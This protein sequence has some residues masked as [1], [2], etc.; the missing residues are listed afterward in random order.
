MQAKRALRAYSIRQFI[1]LT[2]N[3]YRVLDVSDILSD[4]LIMV[5]NF[6]DGSSLTVPRSEIWEYLLK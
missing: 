1:N 6:N 2:D 4:D 5:Y 3:D